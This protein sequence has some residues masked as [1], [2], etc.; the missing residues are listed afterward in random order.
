MKMIHYGLIYQKK[1]IYKINNKKKIY[2]NLV[3]LIF[4]EKCET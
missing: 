4:L 2:H 1:D 3:N